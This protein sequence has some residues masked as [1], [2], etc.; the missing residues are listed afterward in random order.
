VRLQIASASITSQ[1]SL[2]VHLK[3]PERYALKKTKLDCIVEGNEIQ[4]SKGQCSAKICHYKVSPRMRFQISYGAK[5]A[6][7]GKDIERY[8]VVNTFQ[9]F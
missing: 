6:G 1:K 2:G 3:I 9:A 4:K 7:F 8:F 5:G